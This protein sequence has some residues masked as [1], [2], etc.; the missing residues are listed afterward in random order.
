[1][2][3]FYSLSLLLSLALIVGLTVFNLFYLRDRTLQELDETVHTRTRENLEALVSQGAATLSSNFA[4][5]ISVFTLIEGVINTR[6]EAQGPETLPS[7][8]YSQLPA[9]CLQTTEKYGPTPVCFQHSSVLNIGAGNVEMTQRSSRL[10]YFLPN[11]LAAHQQLIL[12]ILVYLEGSNGALVRAFPGSSFPADYD[13]QVQPWYVDL[14]QSGKDVRGTDPYR[15]SFGSGLLIISHARLLRNRSGQIFGVACADTQVEYFSRRKLDI[16]SF[17]T[18]RVLVASLDGSVIQTPGYSPLELANLRSQEPEFWESLMNSPIGMHTLDLEG[19]IYRVAST[20]LGE[21]DNPGNW[22]YVLMVLVNDSEV[23]HD[24][25]PTREEFEKASIWLLLMTSG[26]SVFTA[27]AVLLCVC[28]VERQITS[29]LK[30]ISAFANR[31]YANAANEESALSAELEDL[32]EGQA[33][34]ASLVTTFKSLMRSLLDNRERSADQAEAVSYYSYP[35]N[36]LYN[37]GVRWRA[38]LAALPKD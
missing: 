3:C 20:P 23:A 35:I 2:V 7:Y 19:D 12:R 5:L 11:V 32:K 31:V 13:V 37:G 29:P 17:E 30:G 16:T 28:L 14:I 24:V 36:H 4:S 34:V 27:A 18:A 1:M 22:W 33:Q 21:R 25:T 38:L 10:D 26:C 6:E 9:D 15:D 8:E